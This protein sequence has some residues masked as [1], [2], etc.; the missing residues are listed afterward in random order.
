MSGDYRRLKQASHNFLR[1]MLRKPAWSFKRFVA[2]RRGRRGRR[3]GF[4]DLMK[5]LL[6]GYLSNRSSLRA[7]ER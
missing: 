5:S 4:E 3:W 1:R 2:D 6:A 7:V